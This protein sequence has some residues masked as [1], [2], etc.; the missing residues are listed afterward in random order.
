LQKT[1][2]VADGD[3]SIWRLAAMP[4]A[5]ELFETK[6]FDLAEP[7]MGEIAE[8]CR[9]NEPDSWTTYIAVLNLARVRLAQRNFAGASPL[10][11]EADEGIQKCFAELS[12]AERSAVIDHFQKTADLCFA[13]GAESLAQAWEQKAEALRKVPPPSKNP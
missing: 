10:L 6:Q 11:S 4:L 5:R 9:R 12:E 1:R 2:E 3:G 13:L 8:I 7:V